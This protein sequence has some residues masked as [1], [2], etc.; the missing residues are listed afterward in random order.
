MVRRN[1]TSSPD[2]I[3]NTR[4]SKIKYCLASINFF[5]VINEPVPTGNPQE[6]TNALCAHKIF[7][8]RNYDGVEKKLIMLCYQL[9]Y[10]L[11]SLNLPL[12]EN[13]EHL[14][15][16]QQRM[17]EGTYTLSGDTMIIGCQMYVCSVE[18]PLTLGYCGTFDR[19]PL[20][21]W[22]NIMSGLSS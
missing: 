13:C 15:E 7:D 4:Q 12:Y 9:Y 8:R 11:S 18:N 20:P 17:L 3:L 22:R 21:L 6:E 16:I 10:I 19:G 1:R 14:Q 2:I 5:W